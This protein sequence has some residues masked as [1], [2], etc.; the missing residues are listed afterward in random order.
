M[1]G[2]VV[3]VGMVEVLVVAVAVMWRGGGEE[4]ARWERA[5]AGPGGAAS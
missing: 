2:M 3:V 4:G 1:V 5:R